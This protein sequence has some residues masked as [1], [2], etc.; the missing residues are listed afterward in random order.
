[1]GTLYLMRS[2]RIEFWKMKMRRNNINGEKIQSK[3]IINNCAKCTNCTPWIWMGMWE[4]E[5]VCCV[6]IPNAADG[7]H[8]VGNASRVDI[9]LRCAGDV[10]GGGDCAMWH[11]NS[12]RLHGFGRLCFMYYDAVCMLVKQLCW[13]GMVW[14]DYEAAYLSPSRHQSRS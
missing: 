11:K 12:H 7:L 1:M 6:A 13:D 3:F 9:V 2:S 4:A 14:D 8:N 5:C 10:R